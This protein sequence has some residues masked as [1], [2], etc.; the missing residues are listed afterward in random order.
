MAKSMKSNLV[1]KFVINAPF[2]DQ[3][4]DTAATCSEVVQFF[5]TLP[6]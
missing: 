1:V 4:A 6:P 3:Y 2:M 5:A